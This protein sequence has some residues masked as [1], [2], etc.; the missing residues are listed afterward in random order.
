MRHRDWVAVAAAAALGLTAGPAAASDAG[1]SPAPKTTAAPGGTA[2]AAPV[3]PA[4]SAAQA[5]S[6]GPEEGPPS[7]DEEPSDEDPEGQDLPAGHPAVDANPHAGGGAPPPGVF[8]PPQ[9]TRKEDP[10]LPPGTI[11]VELR[12]ADDHPVSHETVNLGILINSV[13]KGD[14]RKHEQR[15]TDDDGRATF[16]GLETLSN[17]AYRVSVGYQGGSFAALPF[18]MSQGKAM[19]VVLHVYPVTR[20]IRGALIVS[21]ATVAAELR[22]DRIQIEEAL[23]LYNLGRVAWQPDDVRMAL[24]A[25]Y[26]AFGSQTTMSD[27]GV[28]EANGSAK[29]RGTFPPG[30]NTLEFR[31]QLPWSGDA[32]VDFSVGM[33]PHTAIVR[34]MMPATADVKLVATGMPPAEVRQNSQGQSFLVTERRLMQD[35]PKLTALAVGIHDLPTPGPGRFVATTLA[36]LGVAL[37]LYLAALRRPRSGARTGGRTGRDALLEEIADLESAHHSGDVGPRTY[38]RVR[39]ELI[40]ALARTLATTG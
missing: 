9:D 37:G 14:S 6:A 7:S 26:T 16:A 10:T 18:Q 27:E 5:M 13:A 40:D 36:G 3:V 8:Q 28:D 35:D 25:G 20:D 12:D 38:E 15:T 22:D 2:K 23:T 19:R 29:I 21:E 24:P 39:R 1:S 34:L 30:Q 31:W 11:V 4:T 32:N 17:I 33:P